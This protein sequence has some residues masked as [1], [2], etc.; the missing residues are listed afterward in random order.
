M[1]VAQRPGSPVPDLLTPR[2]R[3]RAYRPDDFE[4]VFRR[5][6]LDPRVIRFWH[7]YADPT[8]TVEE[9]RAMA[10]RDLGSWI[11]EAMALGYPAWVIELRDQMPVGQHDRPVG[12]DDRPA[13]TAFVGVTGVF[14]PE[15]DFGPE[16]EVG[17][18]LASAYHGRGLA[19]EAVR[20]VIEDATR[21]LGI[22]VLTAIVDEPNVGSIRVLEKTGFRLERSYLGDD[23]HPYRRYVRAG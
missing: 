11:D 21:R 12:Q 20:A 9:R 15:T 18:L 6:V 10:E 13:V 2:L 19:T 16:P 17:Y 23:G 4:A 8:L 5:L 1:S 3:L 7:A 14:P 22:P